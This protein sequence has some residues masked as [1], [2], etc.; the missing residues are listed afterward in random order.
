M[1]RRSVLALCGA[2]IGSLAGCLGIVPGTGEDGG[3]SP[4]SETPTGTAPRETTAP[5]GKDSE[6]NASPHEFVRVEEVED[7]STVEAASADETAAFQD[8]GPRRQQTFREALDRETVPADGWSYYN[9]SRPVYVRY[10]GTWFRVIVGV[11]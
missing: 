8:L 1:R 3:P 10:N 7:R 11:H 5:A 2:G 6:R 4:N 9:E